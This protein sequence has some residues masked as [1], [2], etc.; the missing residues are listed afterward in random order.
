MQRVPPANYR[1]ALAAIKSVRCC[2]RFIR[3]G[4]V[5]G[6][7]TPDLKIRYSEVLTR[8]EWV[9]QTLCAKPRGAMRKRSRSERRSGAIYVDWTDGIFDK[10]EELEVYVDWTGGRSNEGAST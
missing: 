7:R 4:L 3:E 1:V 8:H 9:G 10:P 2:S 6:T 5:F